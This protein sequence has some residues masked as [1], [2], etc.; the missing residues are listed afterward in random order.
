MG[1]YRRPFGRAFVQVGQGEHGAGTAPPYA[2]TGA[3]LGVV[4]SAYS[5]LPGTGLNL[6]PRNAMPVG[7]AAD[8]SMA[9]AVQMM[10]IEVAAI[11]VVPPVSCPVVRPALE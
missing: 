9:I 11:A 7:T 5:S 4:S 8:A 6:M 1:N 10:L 3:M 2:R